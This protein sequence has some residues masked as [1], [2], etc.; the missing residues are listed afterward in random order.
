MSCTVGTSDA[1]YM[2]ISNPKL[3]P[4]CA[5]PACAASFGQVHTCMELTAT[6]VAT[7]LDENTPRSCEPKEWL[8]N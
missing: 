2:H 7:A 6:G 8:T 1:A 4:A 3:Y 5:A